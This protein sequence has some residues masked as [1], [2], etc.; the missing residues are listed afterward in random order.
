MEAL[1]TNN[2]EETLDTCLLETK[3]AV[4]AN[5]TGSK[6]TLASLFHFKSISKDK[7]APDISTKLKASL[8]KTGA[9]YFG[10]MFVLDKGT[11]VPSPKILKELEK[12]GFYTEP[13]RH[14]NNAQ[15]NLFFITLKCRGIVSDKTFIGYLKYGVE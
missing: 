7:D 12:Q 9:F 1:L 10:P 2:T 4:K 15:L 14:M 8:V 13:L 3:Q 5:V 6:L 11:C